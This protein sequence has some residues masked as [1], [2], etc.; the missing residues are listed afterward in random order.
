MSAAGR[1]SGFGV[2]PVAE[3]DYNRGLHT[4]SPAND[5]HSSPPM[6]SPTPSEDSQLLAL[7]ELL[8]HRVRSASSFEDVLDSILVHSLVA[9]DRAQG[10]VCSLEPSRRLLRLHYRLPRDPSPPEP[11]PVTISAAARDHIQET[12][13]PVQFESP[14]AGDATKEDPAA[15][16]LERLAGFPPEHLVPMGEHGSRKFL[17]SIGFGTG[18][19]AKERLLRSLS[20][21]GDLAS[22]ALDA[23]SKQRR[24]EKKREDG[25]TGRAGAKSG[26]GGLEE[27]RRAYPAFEAVKGGSAALEQIFLDVLSVAPTRCTVLLEGESGTGKELLAR[28]IHQLSD[29][30]GGPFEAVDCAAFPES[31]I[32]S[33]L[34]GHVAGAFTGARRDHRGAF[35]R[36]DGGTVFLDEIG[37]M[38][39]GS[40]SRLLRVLQDNTFKKVGGEKAIRVDVRVVAATNRTLSR[41]VEEGRFREDLFYRVHHFPI[42]IPPLRDRRE[43]IPALV[44]FFLERFCRENG[45]SSKK[46]TPPALKRLQLYRFEGNVRELRNLVEVLALESRRSLTISD[47]H[48]ISVFSRYRIEATG[49]A[50]TGN[51]PSKKP[52]PGRETGAWVLDL[53]RTVE[54]NLADAE[55]NLAEFRTSPPERRPGVPLLGRHSLTYYLQGE[56]F[57]HFLESSCDRERA[58]GI[59]AG[60]PALRRRA[61]HKLNGVLDRVAAILYE[62]E[63]PDDARRKC[64]AK[65]S[66]MPASYAPYLEGLID[67]YYQGKWGPPESPRT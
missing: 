42:R 27:L 43:D 2:D 17:L 61:E 7:L 10:A 26:G 5:F 11:D 34:F 25:K 28:T 37:E 18:R 32:E 58:A 48:V 64:R 46:L 3:L 30:S 62:E 50:A 19:P 33:E 47:Q 65:F 14:R 9:T 8:R 23:Q 6:V 57:R 36:A 29:R 63:D 39:P 4:V 54:F 12:T 51:P 55:R 45:L 20:A 49:D 41:E 44:D 67:S 1:R 56:C 35:E 66:K 21:L 24:R 53:L 16:A 38:S 59:L 22:G 31:L 40:Q 52:K 13:E 15:S 60:N